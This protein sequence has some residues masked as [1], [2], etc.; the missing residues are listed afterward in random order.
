MFTLSIWSDVP[1][2]TNAAGGITP[3]HPGNVLW[4]EPFGPGEYY[5]CPYTNT[6]E[7]FFDPSIPAI[8]GG[9]TKVY[10]LCF[11]PRNPFRQ[12]GTVTAPTNYWLS[13]NAQTTVGGQTRFGWHTSYD[14][15]NDIAVWGIAPFPAAWTPMIDPLGNPL[16][17]AFKVNTRSNPPCPPGTIICPANKTVECG[18]LAFRDPQGD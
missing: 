3:S 1:K 7:Q 16:S 14:Y 17:M 12:T 13:V 9:D 4:S 2:Q 6:S 15:Y 11:Y 8:V 18:T 10:Y 5:Q